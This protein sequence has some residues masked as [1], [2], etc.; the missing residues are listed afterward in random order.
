M[1]TLLLSVFLILSLVVVAQKK[2]YD[3]ELF[4]KKIGSTVV[5]RIDKGGGVVQYKLS[6]NSE[7]NIL[8]THKT[9]IMVFDITYKDGKLLSSYCKNV[10]DDVTEIVTLTWEGTRYVIKKGEEILQLNHMVDFS[11][12][13]LYFIEP[14]GKSKIFSERLGEFCS[15]I[16]KSEGVYE[17]KLASGVTNIYK[18]KN[19]MLYE[20][21][22][23]KGASVFMKFVK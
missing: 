23:S 3:V 11:A 21:E 18:Y 2:T 19:G 12:I 7:V 1:K 17:C 6:S 9:S 14:L 22:M 10:K 16:K 8:F 4:G 5:E 13:Q 15:F 20:M